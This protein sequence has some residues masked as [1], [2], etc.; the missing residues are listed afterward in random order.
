[1]YF[2]FF[3]HDGNST[4]LLIYQLL[5]TPYTFDNNYFHCIIHLAPGM[6]GVSKNE[7]F[8]SMYMIDCAVIF[9]SI[10]NTVY[11]RFCSFK[12]G[13]VINHTNSNFPRHFASFETAAILGAGWIQYKVWKTESNWVQ[14]SLAPVESLADVGISILRE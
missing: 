6:A 2:L 7:K 1:M 9:S 8:E 5:H 3:V 12:S 10:L 13:W 14:K 4:L 11:L